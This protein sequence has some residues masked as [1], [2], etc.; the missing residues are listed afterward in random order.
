[1]DWRNP[2]RRLP[3][4]VKPRLVCGSREPID[5]MNTFSLATKGAEGAKEFQL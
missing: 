1:M 5:R 3:P 2:L 4:A